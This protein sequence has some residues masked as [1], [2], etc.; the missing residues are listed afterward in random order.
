MYRFDA[1]KQAMIA[2]EG[3]GVSAKRSEVEGT[4][5]GY[6]LENVLNDVL[7]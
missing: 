2:G 3:G 6:W 7:M 1:E 4:L 5:A